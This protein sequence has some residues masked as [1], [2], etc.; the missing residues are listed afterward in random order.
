MNRQMHTLPAS[1][2]RWGIVGIIIAKVT[3]MIGMQLGL[4]L[5]LLGTSGVTLPFIEP[6]NRVL[7][8]ISLPLFVVSLGLMAFGAARR[9][10]IYLALVLGGGLLVYAAVFAYGMNLP[11]Y[12]LGMVMLLTPLVAEPVR[13]RFRQW[14]TNRT[15]PAYKV[16]SADGAPVE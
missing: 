9:G 8:P 6:V 11:L 3:C 13:R 4:L 15:T 5:G 1:L 16:S 2:D 14:R 12:L 10:P 7:G